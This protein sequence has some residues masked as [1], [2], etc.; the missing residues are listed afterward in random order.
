MKKENQEVT[1]YFVSHISELHR[2]HAAQ[3]S[4]FNNAAKNQDEAIKS[5]KRSSLDQT[6]TILELRSTIIKMDKEINSLKN[7]V[8]AGGENGSNEPKKA[9]INEDKCDCPVCQMADEEEPASIADLPDEIKA[10]LEMISKDGA[11]NIR[12]VKVSRSEG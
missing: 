10:F 2:Q 6:Q 5:M 12:V 11:S 9:E 8:N 3:I 4:A 1:N 7:N